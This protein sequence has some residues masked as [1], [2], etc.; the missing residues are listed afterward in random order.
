MSARAEEPRE[1]RERRPV[2]GAPDS[3]ARAASNALARRFFEHFL[4]RRWAWLLA[5]LAV[6]GVLG[7]F[8]A[9]VHPDFAVEY[10]FPERDKAKEDYD[11]Y[12]TFF[13]FEDA[14]ALVMV[15]ASDVWTQAGLRR[16][17]AL[18]DDLWRITGVND[19]EGPLS[20]KDVVDAGNE[21]VKVE[22][23]VKSPDLPPAEI[24]AK[25]VTGT[26]DPL[27]QW[28]LS[29]PDGSTVTIRVTL[30]TRYA[31]KDNLRNQFLADLRA[32]VAKHR[33]TQQK[34]LISG[35]PVIRSEYAE[36]IAGDQATTSPLALGLILVLLY[37]TFRSWKEVAAALVTVG[38][39]V[40]WTRG[41]MGILG[42]PE[43]I[44]TGITP[45]VVMIISISDTV[46]IVVHYRE[47]RSRGVDHRAALVDA[48]A[49]CAWPCLVTEITIAAGFLGLYSV[50]IILISQ[51]G[52]ATAV[53]MMLTWAANMTVLPL[54]LWWMRPALPRESER[55]ASADR[56]FARFI[57]WVEQ[58]VT[59]RPRRVA[60]CATA[61]VLVAT[62][63]AM[64]MTREYF[65][66]DD[67]RPGSEI[68]AEIDFAE[69]TFGG[70][71]PLAVFIEPAPGTPRTE[72]M[73]R[74]EVIR[75][76]DRI[77]RFLESEFPEVKNALSVAS[78]LR[79]AH[80]IF[81]G[82]EE[83]A[84][85]PQ[86]LPATLGL[87]AQELEFIDDGMILRDYLDHERSTAAVY[88]PMPDVGSTRV[89]QIRAK[90]EEYLK[91][92]RADMEAEGI[93][94]QITVTGMFAIGEDI[95]RTLVGGLLSSLGIAVGISLL[96]FSAVLQSWRLGLLALV[97]NLLPLAIT[98][99]FM[100]FSGIDLN[101][102]TVMAFSITLVIADDDT[103][104]F[105]ARFHMRFKEV[106]AEDPA[107]PAPHLEASVRTLRE[108]GLPMFITACSVAFGFATLLASNFIG[109]AN[110]GLL[111]GV[112]LFSAVFGDI[113]LTPILLAW[114]R[115]R[116][117]G[118]REAE[119][120]AAAAKPAEA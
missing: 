85:D 94:I 69:R 40:L 6:T 27:F 60:A 28:N 46:H 21:T 79:K 75:L 96:V 58:Q 76:T 50:N 54:A 87:V 83:A 88:L 66:F 97:P 42:Y 16:I 34:I 118:W 101:P 43:Q 117:S 74:P 57:A 77:E 108:A 116:I 4:D 18:E 14:R 13:P 1:E 15:Q 112:S 113:F 120:G 80:R 105:F 99:G 81:A 48:A 89:S 95:Y 9:K 98:F 52:I 110:L 103:V 35:L 10:L 100:G 93:P 29:P 5:L 24:E 82:P 114:S 20:T 44:L 109:L 72:A 63:F 119:G 61:I 47:A 70:C 22:R 56:V 32:V 19:V 86:E 36:M 7:F 31:A 11:R 51:F 102:N 92:E 84:A 71:N 23:L 67:L 90:M 30:T 64:R 107:H 39:C 55:Q 12:K 49:D 111:I 17:Q 37:V 78:Y 91:R 68:R 41:A 104:Q 59:R 26:S 115:P 45:V 106:V 3:S 38:I 2:H 8:G 62:F 73:L 25:R 53:G 33:S 65:A